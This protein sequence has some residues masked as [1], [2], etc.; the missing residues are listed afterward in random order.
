MACPN[1]TDQFST[2]N[3]KAKL[4]Y[5]VGLLSS[6]EMKRHDSNIIYTDYWSMSPSLYYKS[7]SL[8]MAL[9]LGDKYAML[10]AADM[11]TSNGIRP[12][13]ILKPTVKVT[14]SGRQNDPWIVK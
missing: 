5:P 7:E 10:T 13:V 12:V 11:D 2:E 3:P 14:G 4:T 6:P 1:I 9:T 8:I